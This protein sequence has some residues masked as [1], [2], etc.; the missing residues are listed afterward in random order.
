MS[1][2]VESGKMR[3][4]RE[5]DKKIDYIQQLILSSKVFS[6]QKKRKISKVEVDSI[7]GDSRTIDQYVE[8]YF[9]ERDIT[10]FQNLFSLKGK[11]DF[12]GINLSEM[13][14]AKTKPWVIENFR[15]IIAY[16]KNYLGQPT[17]VSKKTKEMIE[18]GEKSFFEK[19]DLN[20]VFM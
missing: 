15:Q 8:D 13:K 1:F 12:D 20:K 5:I 2:V 18:F 4:H 6:K 17:R 14:W 11:Y 3:C 16:K 7:L 19:F 9:Y 10:S